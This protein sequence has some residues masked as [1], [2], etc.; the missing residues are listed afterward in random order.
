MTA[1]ARAERLVN[2]VL[3]LLSSRQYLPAERIRRTVPGY[4]DA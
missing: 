1:A 4:A 3:C 2:L